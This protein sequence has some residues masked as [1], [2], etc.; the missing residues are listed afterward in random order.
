MQWWLTKKKP[1]EI[2]VLV[3]R[4]SEGSLSELIQPGF[5]TKRLSAHTC[6][7]VSCEGPER[8][9]TAIEEHHMYGKH[10][11][12]RWKMSNIGRML[13]LHLACTEQRGENA[14]VNTIKGAAPG[15]L[16]LKFV[17]YGFWC[18]RQHEDTTLLSRAVVFQCNFFLTLQWRMVITFAFV[19]K[20]VRK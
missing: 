12:P 10:V 13:S 20:C 7:R 8:P 4:V 2:I 17:F 3:W 1:R 11:C 15:L 19:S 6:Q 9:L 5:Y 18:E 14:C 16:K